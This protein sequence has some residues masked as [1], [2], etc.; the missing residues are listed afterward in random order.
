MVKGDK[1]PTGEMN[2]FKDAAAYLTPQDPVAKNSN[3]NSKCGA[4]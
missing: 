3:T 4:A 1:G 2:K